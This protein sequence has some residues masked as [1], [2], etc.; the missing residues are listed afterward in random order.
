MRKRFS[1]R[2]MP[3][4]MAGVLVLGGSLSNVSANPSAK[5]GIG[6]LELTRTVATETTIIST[7]SAPANGYTGYAKVTAVAKN[8]KKATSTIVSASS[9]TISK[10]HYKETGKSKFQ[11]ANS[12]HKEY[13][14]GS[15]LKQFSQPLSAKYPN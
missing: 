9:K 11:R 6:E 2:V 10:V 15:E 14:L 8:G 13:Y 7:A 3:L 4:L 12:V 5:K 1:K